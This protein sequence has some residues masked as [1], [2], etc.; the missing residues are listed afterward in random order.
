MKSRQF[1]LTETLSKMAF[2]H[3]NKDVHHI[4]PN[5]PY[6]QRISYIHANYKS[7]ATN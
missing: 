1:T 2:D 7:P 6:L 3:W 5:P 4:R